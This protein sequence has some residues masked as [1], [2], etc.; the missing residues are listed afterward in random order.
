MNQKLVFTSRHLLLA[1]LT[2][3]LLSFSLSVSAATTNAAA[4][5]AGSYCPDSDILLVVA[6]ELSAS[7]DLVMRS[8]VAL[9]D[10]DQATAMTEL[11]AAGT[12]LFLAASR[13][14]DART[15]MLIDAV[16]EAKAGEDYAQ[17]LAWFP[18]MYASLQTLP[19]DTSKSAAQDLIDLAE[20]IMQGDKDGDHLAALKE[21]RQMLA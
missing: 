19:D 13:G 16:I 17:M 4:T 5:K 6:E 9:S 8:R 14:A 20:D 1:C 2:F 7:L 12:T 11:T 10:K 18:R 21:A 3:L 15:T